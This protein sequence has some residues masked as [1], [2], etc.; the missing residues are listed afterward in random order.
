[1]AGEAEDAHRRRLRRLVRRQVALQELACAV[2]A[3][4][5]GRSSD[6]GGPRRLRGS[7]CRPERERQLGGGI[8]F[9]A[10]WK[11]TSPARST[12]LRSNAGL[13]EAYIGYWIDEALAGN[14]LRARPAWWCSASRS[15]SSVFTGWRSPSCRGIARAVASCGS[16]AARGG[17]R[18]RLSRD[19]RQMGGPRPLRDHPEEW[20]TRH[21]D[22]VRTWLKRAERATRPFPPALAGRSCLP[23]M[24]AP[25]LGQRPTFRFLIW[26]L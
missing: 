23:P 12:S 16:W 1:M 7:L 21:K 25:G 2:G 5:S 22:L 13:P 20:Q 24:T 15:K 6:G 14:G 8:G 9:G 26:C 19:R 4:A 10:S 18:D 17:Y 3:E 11:A